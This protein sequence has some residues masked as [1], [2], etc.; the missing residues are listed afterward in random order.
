MMA[1]HR[2]RQ[3]L[4]VTAVG[5]IGIV[6]LEFPLHQLVAQRSEIARTAAALRSVEAHNASLAQSISSLRQSSTIASI[7]HREYGLVR[8]GQHSYV[9]LPAANDRS[10]R[11]ASSSSVS[12]IDLGAAAQSGLSLAPASTSHPEPSSLW[13]RFVSHLEFW[14]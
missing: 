5:A 10:S 7:A 11:R 6:V 4:I 2:A 3:M 14:R 9:I 1:I 8:P 13:S 12:S